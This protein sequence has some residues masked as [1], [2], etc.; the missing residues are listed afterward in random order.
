MGIVVQAKERTKEQEHQNPKECKTPDHKIFNHKTPDHNSFQHDTSVSVPLLSIL[1]EALKKDNSE[2]TEETLEAIAKEV[3]DE[4]IEESSDEKR[5]K[6]DP[7]LELAEKIKR[8][9]ANELKEQVYARFLQPNYSANL[10][11]YQNEP[12][13]A[14]QKMMRT[15]YE[16]ENNESSEKLKPRAI[17]DENSTGYK[18]SKGSKYQAFIMTDPRGRW[19]STW[20]IVRILNESAEGEIERNDSLHYQ[21]LS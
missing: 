1:V 16:Q 20:E 4:T 8:M 5:K 9:Y 19:H 18:I 6:K 21:G 10:M 3:S 2:E 17:T 7:I 11:D 15:A 13:N 14:M 12:N